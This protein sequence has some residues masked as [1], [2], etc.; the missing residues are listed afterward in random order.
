MQKAREGVR[1]RGRWSLQLGHSGSFCCFL[2]VLSL[3]TGMGLPQALSLWECLLWYGAAPTP[4]TSG[5]SFC[6]RFLPP[7]SAPFFSPSLMGSA[8]ACDLSRAMWNCVQHS[9]WPST[10]ATS[11][12][13]HYQTLATPTQKLL[14]IHIS[15]RKIISHHF[16]NWIKSSEIWSS[17]CSRQLSQFFSSQIG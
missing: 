6:F 17:A 13:S 1:G 3:C 5:F 12:T 10:G 7:I 11:A 16:K 14:S 2:Y 15:D 9:P 8:L 4:P